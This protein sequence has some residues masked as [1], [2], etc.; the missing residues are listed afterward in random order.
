MKVIS[1]DSSSSVVWCGARVACAEVFTGPME[2]SKARLGFSC[3]MSFKVPFCTSSTWKTHIGAV[4][5]WV[6][7]L[8]LG[9]LCLPRTLV[10]SPLCTMLTYLL[11]HLTYHLA[12]QQN[13]LVKKGKKSAHKIVFQIA[14]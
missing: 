10:L 9:K 1:A 11:T 2:A 8:V 4:H 5:S 6:S 13:S 3:H 14:T 12:H 7:K